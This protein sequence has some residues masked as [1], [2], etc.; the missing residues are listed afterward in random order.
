MYVKTLSYSGTIYRLFSLMSYELG[1]H[2][3]QFNILQL[4][5]ARAGARRD[6]EPLSTMQKMIKNLD[7]DSTIDDGSHIV[8]IASFSLEDECIGNCE[9]RGLANF[10][11]IPQQASGLKDM[12]C[13]KKQ[14]K[15][16]LSCATIG[17]RIYANFNI[18][19]RRTEKKYL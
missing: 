9:S 5:L 14:P 8:E 16:S 15:Y 1:T 19:R 13:V 2:A 7:L 17:G 3:K 10:A 12:I 11:S 18:K 6:Q 4:M